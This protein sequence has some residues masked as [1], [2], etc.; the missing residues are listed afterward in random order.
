MSHEMSCGIALINDKGITVKPDW[1]KS[2][3]IASVGKTNEGNKNIYYNL[4]CSLFMVD[5]VS[6]MEI[7]THVHTQW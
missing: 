6:L 4:V 7:V 3:S 2:K 1:W 5:Y